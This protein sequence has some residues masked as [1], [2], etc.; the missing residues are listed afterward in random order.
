MRYTCTFKW[1]LI[2]VLMTQ[3]YLVNGNSAPVSSSNSS[4]LDSTGTSKKC[5]VRLSLHLFFFFQ[6]H[7]RLYLP[8]WGLLSR[9]WL[10]L[11]SCALFLPH[12]AEQKSA[13]K[14][15]GQKLAGIS[16]LCHWGTNGRCV[17]GWAVTN[18]P[19][20]CFPPQASE[21][22]RALHMRNMVMKY[23]MRIQPEWKNQV[24]EGDNWDSTVVQF[25]IFN[26]DLTR[27]P[28]RWHRRLLPVRS[29]R[30]RKKATLRALAGCFWTPGSVRVSAL[31]SQ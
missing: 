25:A 5:H 22:L 20:I 21:H 2:K 24:S 28:S 9:Q 11:G 4:S 18:P 27:L 30:I 19:L 13:H 7:K 14:R 10:F 15:F 8:S 12:E 29:S 3:W 1:A 31:S 16:S 26:A 17:V 6:V 23:C